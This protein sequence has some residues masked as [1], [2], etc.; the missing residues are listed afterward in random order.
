[1]IP[2]TNREFFRFVLINGL[3]LGAGVFLF[4]YLL[5]KFYFR[6]FWTDEDLLRTGAICLLAGF[7]LTLM[8]IKYLKR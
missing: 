4:V 6:D 7:S 2:R 3:A 1:V 5:H 8:R